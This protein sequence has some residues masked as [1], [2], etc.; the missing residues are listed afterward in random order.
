MPIA[1]ERITAQRDEWA[2]AIGRFLVAFTGCEY[3]TYQYIETFSSKT[4]REAVTDLGLKP[5]SKLAYAIL[6][7]LGLVKNIQDRVEKAFAELERLSEARNL[8]AHNG[9]M[10]H[11][12]KNLETKV[13]EI[14]HELRSAK[15]AKKEITI[16]EL[17][18]HYVEATDLEE[19]FALL[20][21][22]VRLTENRSPT[23]PTAGS[24]SD[25]NA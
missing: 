12:Y 13:Y 10:I 18:Q 7:D 24:G 19:E 25:S 3:W 9:P 16:D 14:R 2:L 4:L 15:N 22:L 6:L 1:W 21:G 11:V 8:V 20:F 5:R 17:H 23:I